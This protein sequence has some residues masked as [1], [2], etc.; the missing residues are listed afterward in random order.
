MPDLRAPI[1][2]AGIVRAFQV[3]L[4][5]VSTNG[6]LS[7]PDDTNSMN[8]QFQFRLNGLVITHLNVRPVVT[9][10][11]TDRWELVACHETLGEFAIDDNEELADPALTRFVLEVRDV[12]IP[13]TER[14]YLPNKGWRRMTTSQCL[15]L[16]ES[17]GIIETR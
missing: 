10:G 7:K 13:P 5:T 1:L 11:A 15:A 17:A 9:F 2:K 8:T 12:K 4:S 14:R 16:L 3:S 6:E